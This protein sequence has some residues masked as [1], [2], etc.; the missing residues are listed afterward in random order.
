MG[1]VLARLVRRGSP[2]RDIEM[3]DDGLAGIL[4]FD[5]KVVVESAGDDKV[6]ALRLVAVEA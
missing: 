5:G 6:I 2:F 1:Q 4:R 3:P